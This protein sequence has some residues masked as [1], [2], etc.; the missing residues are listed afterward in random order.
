MSD[1]APAH[2]VSHQLGA[3]LSANEFLKE[4]V[5]EVR[6]DLRRNEEN[7][8]ALQRDIGELAV[9]M[10]GLAKD[11]AALAQPVNQY[12]AT[13]SRLSSLGVFLGAIALTLGFV[14]GP[15]WPDVMHKLFPWLQQ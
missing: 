5:S 1:I 14:V 15:V 2:T 11:V 13:R 7:T 9:A 12:V 8:R 6:A 3:M 10:R 4:Q